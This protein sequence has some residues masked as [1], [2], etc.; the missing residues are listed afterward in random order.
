MKCNNTDIELN[1]KMKEGQNIVLPIKFI[2]EKYLYYINP[3]EIDI[4]AARIS[5]VKIISVID[6]NAT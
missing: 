2:I 4:T 1:E 6:M 5:N 3:I